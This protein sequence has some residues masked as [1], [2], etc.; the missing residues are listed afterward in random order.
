MRLGIL[1]FAIAL[2]GCATAG[3]GADKDKPE[4]QLERS[5]LSARKL[6]PG[7]CGLYVWKADSAKNFILFSSQSESA[8][9][10]DEAELALTRSS[11]GK[12][13]TDITFT[14]EAGQERALSLLDAEEIEGGI[15]YKAGRLVSRTSDGWEKVVPIVGL[16]ACQPTI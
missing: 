1:I 16:Y 4:A 2:T 6:G 10:E 3:G 14:D 11:A 12:T 9:F 5:G 7:E 13:A 15:R 8:L